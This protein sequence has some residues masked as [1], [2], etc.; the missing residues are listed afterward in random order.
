MRNFIHYFFHHKLQRRTVGIIWLSILVFFG[1]VVILVY[2]I[3]GN[4]PLAELKPDSN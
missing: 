3:V 1:A 4:A 2:W